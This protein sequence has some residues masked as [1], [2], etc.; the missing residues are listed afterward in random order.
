[1]RFGNTIYTVGTIA[2]EG[3]WGMPGDQ[4]VALRRTERSDLADLMHELG[5][6]FAI[7]D[8]RPAR[9]PGHWLL[10]P[11]RGSI[12]AQVSHVYP[13]VWPEVFDAVLYV[14]RMTPAKSVVPRLP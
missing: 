6:D 3:E 5:H 12:S 1:M 8:L 13:V 4:S 7:L 11:S 10:E 14:S 9:T 2:Y